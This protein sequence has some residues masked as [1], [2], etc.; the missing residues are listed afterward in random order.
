VHSNEEEY[1]IDPTRYRMRRLDTEEELSWREYCANYRSGKGDISEIWEVVY[2]Y[3][4]L[5]NQFGNAIFDQKG[6]GIFRFWPLLPYS[7]S[8]TACSLHEGDTPL[9]KARHYGSG[10]NLYLKN[11]SVNPTGSFKDRYDGLSVNVALTMG[12][13]KL[14]CASTGNHAL[15]VAAY[16]SVAGMECLSIVADS[17]SDQVLAT[18]RTYGAEVRVVSPQSRFAILAEEAMA[19]AYPVGLFMPG[20]TTNPFGVEG[21]KTIAYEVVE[22]LGCVPD[23]VIFPCARGNGLYGAWKG[24]RE[25][26]QL[27]VVESTPR[28]YACQPSV[29]ASLVLAYESRQDSPAIVDPGKTIADAISE[30]VSSQQA[31][32][33]IR[34]SK[35][36]AVAVGEDEIYKAVFQLGRE[37][38]FSE[39]SSAIVLSGIKQ[40]LDVGLLMPQETV[41]AV[42]TSS[43]FKS[44]TQVLERIL[45]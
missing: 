27:G 13:D 2:D 4:Q 45:A 10:L 19:G 42:V 35:G 30:D 6:P 44:G 11:E 16:A 17:A 22:Q 23:A 26:N 21:Y 15:S 28:M 25:L 9:V 33:A 39:P 32:D 43:G 40:L 12:F 14:V 41:V 20:P 8:E 1:V 36:A 24:F 5:V 37:G 7:K 34:Q 29:A 38:V 3:E 31:L 18:L